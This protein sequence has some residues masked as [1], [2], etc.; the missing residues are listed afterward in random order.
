VTASQ[1]INFAIMAFTFIKFKKACEAQ[2]LDRNTLPYKSWWQPFCAWY[3]FTGCFIM[4]FVGGYP[5]FILDRWDIPTFLF[6]YMMIFVFPVLFVG[7]KFLKKTKWLKPHEVDLRKDVDEIEEY[8]RTYVPI[9]PRYMLLPAI[10][11][12]SLTFS[13]EQVHVLFRQSFQLTSATSMISVI[14]SHGQS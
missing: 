9:P 3:A 13:Q 12:Q 14:I 11:R 7:W 4:A 6:S 10:S 5:V 2:G 1:L 8:Q